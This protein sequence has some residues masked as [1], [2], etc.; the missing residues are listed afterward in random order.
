MGRGKGGGA[1]RGELPY[2]C[3]ENPVLV[4]RRSLRRGKLTSHDT[5]RL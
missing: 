3:P 2:R 4:Y 5:F 1:G